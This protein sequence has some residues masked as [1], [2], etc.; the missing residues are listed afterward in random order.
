MR[1]LLL[2]MALTL[3]AQAA[4]S[5][6]LDTTILIKDGLVGYNGA[7]VYDPNVGGAINSIIRGCSEPTITVRLNIDATEA[8]TIKDT[9]KLHSPILVAGRVGKTTALTMTKSGSAPGSVLDTLFT[10]VEEV[11]GS[12]Q[13]LADSVGNQLILTNFGFARKV[14]NS[15]THSVTIQA[16]G[17]SVS[18]CHFWMLDKDNQN[19][20]A[21]LDIAADSVLVERSL[22][23]APS[24]GGGRTSGVHTGGTANKVEIR[25]NVFFSTNVQIASKGIFH[26]IANTFCGSRDNFNAIVIGSLITTDSG[27]VNNAVIMHNLFAHKADSLSPIIFNAK[28][29]A[30][31]SIL[32]NAWSR[33]KPNMALA[34]ANASTTPSTV[35]LNGATLGNVNT[36][37]PRGFSNYGPNSYDVKDYPLTELRSDPTLAR[38]NNDFGKIFRVFVSSSWSTMNDILSLSP[39]GKMIFPGFSPFLAGKNW[40]TNVKVGAFV[41]QDTYETP[42]PLDSGSQGASLK[43]QRDT[44]TSTRIKMTQTRY[45]ANYYKSSSLTP[46]FMY[47]FFSNTLSKLIGAGSND[48]N[49]L[50]NAPN[51]LPYVRKDFLNDDSLLTV[52]KEVRTGAD[53]YVKMLHF[54]QGLQA[55]VQSQAVIATVTGFPSFPVNDLAVDVK[56]PPISD[57]AGGHVTLSVT[58]GSEPIDSIRVL[59]I[60]EGGATV[61]ST[62]KA[63]TGT[64]TGF[65]ID[66]AGKGNFFFAA[67]PVAKIGTLTKAGAATNPLGP[68]A[69]HTSTSDSVFVTYK[70]GT[71]TGAD[72]TQ[73]LPYCSLDSAL[74]DVA[75]KKGGTIIIKNGS[76][77]VVLED[78]IV[79]ALSGTDTGLVTITSGKFDESRP[80]IRGKLREALTIT[81]R[82]VTVRGFTFEQPVN[83]PNNILTVKASGAIID[84][85]I[86]RAAASGIVEGAAVNID[87]GATAD[88]RIINNVMWGISKGIQITNSASTAI[89]IMNNT[90]VEDPVLANAGRTIGLTQSGA[91]VA[92]PVLANNFFSGTSNPID[93]TITGTK[94]IMDHNVFTSGHPSLRGG[95]DAGGLDSSDRVATADVWSGTYTRNLDRE[96]SSV[97]DCNSLSDCNPIYAGSSANGYNVVVSSDVF[98]KIRGNKHEVGAFEFP[99]SPTSVLGTL[100]IDVTLVPKTFERLNYTV[101]SKN[102]DSDP[103][104][105]DSVHVFWSTT[106]LGTNI[107]AS[108]STIPATRKHAYPISKLTSGSI[109]DF[110]D[111]IEES[112][113]YYFY[114]AIGR[115][116]GTR[117]LG[118]AYL[119]TLTSNVNLSFDSCTFKFSK[120]ACPSDNGIFGVD[121]GT[122]QYK[123]ET[124]VKLNEALSTG[125]VKLPE[126]INV[127]QA[128][129]YNLDLTSPLPTFSFNT[130][131]PNLGVDQS[132][133]KVTYIVDTYLTPD[134]TGLDL[135]LLPND[136]AGMAKLVPGWTKV[137]GG[138]GKTRIT[139]ESNVDGPQV[140]AFGKV[141]PSL[142]PGVVAAA[143]TGV[144]FYDFNAARDSSIYHVAVKLKGTGF[145]TGN[146]LVLVSIIPAG[147]ALEKVVSK[148][149]HSKTLVASAGYAILPDSLKQARLYQHYLKAVAA[150][151]ASTVT[152]GTAKPFTLDA[153]TAGD[154]DDATDVIPVDLSVTAGAV[155]EM[156]VSIPVGKLF[157]DYLKY[158]DAKGKASRSIEVEYTS[159]DGGKISRNR[160][161][162]QTRFQEGDLQISEKGQRSQ[163]KRSTHDAPIWNLF[164][165][166]WDEADT[167]S[168]ARVVGRTKFETD[169][170]RLMVYKG[171]G[172]GAGAFT[173][174]TG[175]NMAE[176][177]YDAGQAIWSGSTSAYTPNSASG[178]TLDYKQFS[179]PLVPSQWND[180]CLP[181]NFPIKW[182]AILDTSGLTALTAPAVFHYNDSAKVKWEPVTVASATPGSVGTILNPWEGYTVKPSAAVTLRFPIMDKDRSTTPVTAKTAANDGSW[183]VKVEASGRTVAMDLSVG[184]AAREFTFPEAPNV[185]GQDF[186][187]S[188]KRETEAGQVNVSQYIQRAE[189][190][191]Q[192]HWALQA[193]A[194]KGA[195]NISFRILETTRDIPV[196]LVDILH[197]SVS[198]LQAGAPVEVGEDDIRANEYHLVA[199]DQAYLDGILKGLVPLHLLALSNYPN[200]FKGSTLIRY[201]LPRSFGRVKFD[202][203]VRDFKGRVVW[204]KS[205]QDG[206]AA[207]SYLWDGRDRGNTVLPSG[208][209]SLSLTAQAPGKPAYRAV[210]SIL[211]M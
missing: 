113:L 18:A 48:T 193:S 19:T 120:S 181:F 85:N 147:S 156:T 94:V 52:P 148:D 47:F 6:C 87:V 21:L 209:Y 126:F 203:K 55:P 42:S 158:K 163:F 17:S 67:V 76:P 81:R 182:Q 210:R 207:L 64:S 189:G 99:G 12:P 140:Y 208:V 118:F 136:A 199:G 180:I 167:G 57:F 196:W 143:D 103:K 184:M 144:P 121:T 146:P 2:G 151:A 154:F 165:Y 183:A 135:F 1:K 10:L 170:T 195:G 39:A 128:D 31:D 187:V 62:A 108:L 112:K 3:G 164:G 84:A 96:F 28:A 191:W 98:G 149:Y 8:G 173:A 185:P 32:R 93:S 49:T 129:L 162:I 77:A 61:D 204:E 86:F 38:K 50:K 73:S 41:D 102:F 111:G 192:G 141:N 33:G 104:E 124:R 26:I 186:R 172:T 23:R 145:K 109:V 107:D 24:D 27:N 133:Q 16:K 166:P 138:N 91:A 101:S 157:K 71:C 60:A 201:S 114:A 13:L 190:A 106:N 211:R 90:F 75:A 46:Q 100:Q 177:R 131:I 175:S 7:G 92:A 155:G 115:N 80:I 66:I 95:S 116:T 69:I 134:L 153:L 68:F 117:K 152:K 150:E 35:T 169:N 56:L 34:Q 110:A 40:L 20:G 125:L 15:A 132:N 74:K 58:K 78:I 36:P 29:T 178:A 197:G 82:N 97:I 53:I 159:F 54:R 168:L 88:V 79:P 176:M 44:S 37:L 142:E 25:A 9:L 72:G 70:S 14:L 5:D 63:A 202:L 122:W 179:L 22:F 188:L 119:D 4:W 127:K 59:V 200:P 83:N 205:V 137:D 105:A 194:A 139:F 206:T 174:Y 65:N 45:D 198:Q 51:S 161:F 89:K 160:A 130:T 171:S 43:F 123:F 30:S 11:S